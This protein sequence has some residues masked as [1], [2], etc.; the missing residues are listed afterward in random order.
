MAFAYSVRFSRC[1]T[2][3]PGLS[4]RG[5]VAIDLRFEPVAQPFVLGQRRTRQTRAAA[6]RPR[7][8]CGSP[9]P[10]ARRDRRPCV[11]SSPCSDR[12][13]VFSRSLWQVT[14]YLIEKRARLVCRSWRRRRG[15]LWARRCRLPARSPHGQDRHC[16][17]C[18]ADRHESN[19]PQR[20]GSSDGSAGR[21]TPCLARVARETLPYQARMAVRPLLPWAG[22]LR[23][24]RRNQ[25]ALHR[26]LVA[27]A[28]ALDEVGVR[29][30]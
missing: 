3:E 25:S 11:R 23:R 17:E 16:A 12:F 26:F 9:S 19:G 24:S 13:A 21:G 1:R 6:S 4:L 29:E 22:R 7:A 14:Q 15:A 8:A 20:H 5:R 28:E 2:T 10:T 30:Q 27:V 18:A